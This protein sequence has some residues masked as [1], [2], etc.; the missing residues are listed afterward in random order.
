VIIIKITKEFKCIGIYKILN[1]LNGKFYIGSS[2]D[3]HNRLMHHRK[4]LRG[5]YHSNQH[6]QRAY[7]KY[8]EEN[9]E[10]IILEVI[11]DKNNLLDREQYWIDVTKCYEEEIGYNLVK[12]ALAPMFGKVF[13]VEHRENISKNRK[14]KTSG[15]NHHMYGK[16]GH[17]TGKK[18]SD[19]AKGKISIKSKEYWTEENRFKKSQNMKNKIEKDP[20]IKDRLASYIAGREM[21]Q[22][23]KDKISE[24]MMGSKHHNAKLTEDIVKEIK[25]MLR[26]GFPRKEISK[27]YNISENDVGRI[28][29]GERWKHVLI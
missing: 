4:R 27:I 13:T 12:S 14:G 1:L 3:I 22:E 5:G 25:I 23:E 19:E 20:S 8:K 2:V 6:L 26:E 11:A 7:N 9:F 24:R 21:P 15:V 16:Q 18:H 17:M 29:R 28:A 10:F